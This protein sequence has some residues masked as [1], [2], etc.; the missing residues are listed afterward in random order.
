MAP[1]QYEESTAWGYLTTAILD[2]NA[3]ERRQLN[4]ELKF[5]VNGQRADKMSGY[6][7]LISNNFPAMYKKVE[8]PKT[9]KKIAN[10][11]VKNEIEMLEPLKENDMRKDEPVKHVTIGGGTVK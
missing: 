10:I 6:Q 9:V 4:N 11:Q 5:I 7:Y 1:I 2:P 3:D 8:K